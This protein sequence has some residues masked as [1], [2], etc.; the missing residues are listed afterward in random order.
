[1]PFLVDIS[2]KIRSNFTIY[3]FKWSQTAAEGAPH[4]Q[5]RSTKTKMSEV[6]LLTPN[7]KYTPIREQTSWL[8]CLNQSQPSNDPTWSHYKNNMT[9]FEMTNFP[10]LEDNI[11]DFEAIRGELAHFINPIPRYFLLV[12]IA[13]KFSAFH[14]KI[15]LLLW[16]TCWTSKSV[17]QTHTPPKDSKSSYPFA[18][19]A[20]NYE[21]AH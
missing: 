9:I 1:M 4:H 17:I 18:K 20:C 14:C 16:C 13:Q 15:K 11:W 21:K 10:Q 2:V 3:T 6:C 5:T 7:S 12:S 19:N 8:H